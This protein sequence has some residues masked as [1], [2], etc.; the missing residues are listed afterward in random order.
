MKRF[1][2]ALGNDERGATAV[3]YAIM[4]ALIAV[5]IVGVVAALGS[6]VNGGLF[7]NLLDRMTTAGIGS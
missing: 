6:S 4:A 2:C 7:V 1:A 5:V 3:E